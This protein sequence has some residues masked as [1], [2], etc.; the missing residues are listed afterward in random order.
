M[1]LSRLEINHV[2][3][4]QS[5]SLLPH[6]RLNILTGINGS[7]KTSVLEALHL[8]GLG[9]SFRSGRAR[10]LVNDEESFCT[11]FAEFTQGNQ[12]G[13]Q[14]F[15]NGETNLRLDGRNQVTLA[16]MAQC[17]PLTLLDPESMDLLDAGSKPRRALL[18]WGVF[19]VEHRFFPMWQRYQ[20][21]LKQRNSLLRSGSIGRLESAPWNKELSESALQLHQFRLDYLARWQPVWETKVKALLPDIELTLDYQPGWDTSQNL[22]E[23]LAA[24]WEKDQERGHTQLGAHRADLRVKRGTAAAD[25]VLSRGQKKLLVCAL[26][27]SQVA[28][29]RSQ[30]VECVLLVDDLASELDASARQR[31]IDDLLEDGAQVFITS[32]EASSI[33][34]LIPTGDQ[35]FKMFHV[36]HGTL[37]EVPERQMI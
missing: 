2:R 21:A 26:R 23:L 5:V 28:L 8:L 29:L 17:L 27:L 20:R 10:R 16:E 1:S 24:S 33:V 9:R 4:L 25:E 30:G 13:I 35:G 36:E 34:P 37:R 12:A 32:I 6:P 19:H 22:W 11:V 15:A 31:L 7:G 18:D 14:R 3:N